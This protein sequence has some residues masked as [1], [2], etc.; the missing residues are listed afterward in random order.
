[1]CSSIF[2]T[3]HAPKNMYLQYH[4]CT[5]IYWIPGACTTCPKCSRNINCDL[6]CKEPASSSVRQNMTC[7]LLS[8]ANW[9]K[10]NPGP[11]QAGG[12]IVTIISIQKKGNKVSWRRWVF[13]CRRGRYLRKREEKDLGAG[14]PWGI[15]LA[16]GLCGGQSSFLPSS[17]FC[18]LLGSWSIYPD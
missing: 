14:K 6:C 9:E 5:V 7:F 4:I 8:V 16:P 1:M 12:S 11:S 3:W 10:E 15:C 13:G 17:F 18:S 2:T